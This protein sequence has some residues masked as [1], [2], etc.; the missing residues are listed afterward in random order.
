MPEK[1]EVW[2]DVGC[3]EIFWQM[4]EYVDRSVLRVEVQPHAVIVMTDTK[5]RIFRRF[6]LLERIDTETCEALLQDSNVLYIK[7]PTVGD[8]Q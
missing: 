5:P 1:P 7:C 8:Y 3:V 2:H 6:N 4:P